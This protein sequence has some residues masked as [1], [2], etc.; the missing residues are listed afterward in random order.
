M[1]RLL[2]AL[3]LVVALS[4]AA[5]ADK[6][7]RILTW[8]GYVSD[9]DLEA[10]N[11]TLAARG[12]AVRAEVI[13]PYAEGPEQMFMLLRANRADLSFL[14][15]NYIKMQKGRIT[16]LLQPIDT[17]RLANYRQVLPELASLEMGM[18]GGQLFYVPFGG[19]SYAIWAN[20]QRLAPDELPR[21]LADLLNPRWRGRLSLTSGQVQPNVALA[22]MALGD[23]PFLLHDLM[24]AGRRQEARHIAAVDGSA[25]A[26]LNRLYAQVGEFWSSAPRFADDQLLVASY[27]PEL[28]PLHAQGKDW[29]QVEFAEGNT[30]W[31]D[32]LNIA[33]GVEGEKLEAAY[34]AIDHFLTP[35]VQTRVV[36]ELNMVAA[37]STVAN[38]QLAASPD[39]FSAKRFWPP[40]NRT[41]DNLMRQM[42]DHAMQARQSIR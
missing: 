40:Y 35:A 36:A 22:F 3:L 20:M 12:L 13:S 14:T 7:L 16:G 26:F 4:S 9:A 10:I 1:T 8:E 11:A 24:R 33:R 32:T 6:T 25:Q 42:S 30:V 38:P 15:L 23:P 28:A 29:R 41:A 17:G 37:V 19:G 34:L 39:L 5:R 18:A 2:F 31:L 21:R 27:G